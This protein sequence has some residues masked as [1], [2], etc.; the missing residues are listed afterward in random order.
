V[1]MEAG[2]SDKSVA[3]NDMARAIREVV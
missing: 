2:L 3:L 1:V